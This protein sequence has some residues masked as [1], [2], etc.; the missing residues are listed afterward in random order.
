[1][2]LLIGFAAIS[3]LEE[4]PLRTTPGKAPV[5]AAAGE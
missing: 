1:V 2:I 3:F 4:V 5:H